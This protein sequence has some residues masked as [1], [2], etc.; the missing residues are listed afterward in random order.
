M[1]RMMYAVAGAVVALAPLVAV[2]APSPSP[3][4]DKVLAAAPTSDYEESQSS[5]D[6]PLG[7]LDSAQYAAGHAS[8]P[9]N[10]K[11]IQQ[12][13]DKAGFIAGYE[14][15]WVNLGTGIVL[16]ELVVAFNGGKGAKALLAASEQA[17]KADPTYV[18]A[19]AITGIDP[20]YGAYFND[21]SNI[22]PYTYGFSFVKG[23][24]YFFVDTSANSDDGG[25]LVST[26]TRMQYDLAPPYTIPPSEW[27]QTFPGADTIIT[28][29]IRLGVPLAA[30]TF[31]ILRYRRPR[32]HLAGASLQLSPDGRF[33][34]DGREWKDT[35]QGIPPHAQ[36]SADG[37]YWWDGTRWRPAPP[38][39]RLF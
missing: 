12:A 1:N 13:L 3:A 7:P 38:L 19:L 27:P 30:L 29:A 33:W 4:L 22:V 32:T 25:S 2:A 37:N 24:D 10:L 39:R 8:D 26:Q 36:Q 31:L 28:W 5:A 18:R 17:D 34:W 6:A 15:S 16:D 35:E 11:Q 20:Y 14:R 9:A 23:N 21:G